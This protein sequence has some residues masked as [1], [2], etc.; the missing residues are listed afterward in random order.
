VWLLIA[1]RPDVTRE[2]P[3]DHG[4]VQDDPGTA[5]D[6]VA[7]PAPWSIRTWEVTATPGSSR[8]LARLGT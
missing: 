7:R 3:Y 2:V 6:E 8:L 4:E 1:W 5:V